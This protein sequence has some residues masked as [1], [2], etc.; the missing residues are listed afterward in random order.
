MHFLRKKEDRSGLPF[1]CNYFR[2]LVSPA[3]TQRCKQD[4]KG[5]DLPT[6]IYCA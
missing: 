2:K 6:G 3:K 5:A 4:K 1:I